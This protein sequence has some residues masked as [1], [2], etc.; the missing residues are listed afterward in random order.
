M[1]F[2]S[3]AFVVFLTGVLIALALAKTRVLRQLVMLVS[4]ALFYAYWNKWYLLLLATPSVI[5]YVCARAI[6]SA[7]SRRP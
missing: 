7:T 4:S 3:W 2:T 1:V 6:A 5:D